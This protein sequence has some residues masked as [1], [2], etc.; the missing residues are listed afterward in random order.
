MPLM[1]TLAVK[2]DIFSLYGHFATRSSAL[3]VKQR[4]SLAARL[5]SPPHAPPPHARQV[6]SLSSVLRQKSTDMVESKDAQAPNMTFMSPRSKH[7]SSLETLKGLRVQAMG[8][9]E[10]IDKQ[11]RANKLTARERLEVL[12]DSGSFLE[13][14]QLV[15]HRLNFRPRLPL[16]SLLPLMMALM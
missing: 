7:T 3:L 10:G 9:Q 11:H 13:Y 16:G 4:Y 12:L 8:T 1:S 5:L 6:A 14:D 15:E 2:H